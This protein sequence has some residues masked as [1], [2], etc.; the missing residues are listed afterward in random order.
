M[1]SIRRLGF[2]IILFSFICSAFINLFYFFMAAYAFAGIV[3]SI[4][5]GIVYGSFLFILLTG[6]YF[7]GF[8]LS[9]FGGWR[10]VKE[11]ASGVRMAQAGVFMT[12]YFAS[13][14]LL[15]VSSVSNGHRPGISSFLFIFNTL[16]VALIFS[17][18]VVLPGILILKQLKKYRLSLEQTKIEE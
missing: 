11:N 3:T 15:L 7:G 9:L 17:I 6:S 10:L 4:R 13:L 12:V 8:F 2:D 1:K 16:V 18:P 5:V 14:A